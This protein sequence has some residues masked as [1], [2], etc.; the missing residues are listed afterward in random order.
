M[1]LVINAEKN[2]VLRDEGKSEINEKW[3]I[4]NNELEIVKQFTELRII[5][6]YYTKFTKAKKQLS[7]K[8]SK[9]MFD[10][11]KNISGMLLNHEILLSLMIITFMV[12]S[13]MHQK[14]RALINEKC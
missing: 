2:V 6:Q 10:L 12:L 8:G 13:I 5:F 9:A 7:D 1:K 3:F 14:F 11:M 4:G